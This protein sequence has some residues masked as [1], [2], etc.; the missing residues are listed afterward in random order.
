MHRSEATA[1]GFVGRE[2]EL[3]WIAASW[4]KANEESRC[5]L[6]TV[7][8][9]AGVGK[10]R[11]VTEALSGIEARIVRGRCLPYGEGITYW[12]V[13]EVVKQVTVLPVGSF[14]GRGDPVAPGR[15]GGRNE[16]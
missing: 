12:P 10:S 11:L 1:R 7:V 9:D 2:T 16:Q 13:V 3:A 6:V 5:E 4:Q 8:G 15:I 14:C